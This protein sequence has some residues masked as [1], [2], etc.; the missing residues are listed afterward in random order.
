MMAKARERAA[1]KNCIKF[2]QKVWKLELSAYY[3][4]ARTLGNCHYQNEE[5]SKHLGTRII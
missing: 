2:S 1:K 4:Y 5:S 3:R